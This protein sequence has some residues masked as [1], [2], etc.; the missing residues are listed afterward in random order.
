MKVPENML[1][2]ACDQAGALV[3]SWNLRKSS[4]RIFKP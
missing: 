3:D 4:Y 2:I 1:I